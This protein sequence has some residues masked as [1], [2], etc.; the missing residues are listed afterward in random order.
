MRWLGIAVLV[1]AACTPAVSAAP[2]P[3]ASPSPIPTSSPTPSPVPTR[4]FDVTVHF[5]SHGADDLVAKWTTELPPAWFEATRGLS[6]VTVSPTAGWTVNVFGGRGRSENTPV[7]IMIYAMSP[8]GFMNVNGTEY[9]DIHVVMHEMAHQ[10][11]CCRGPDTEGGHFIG[12]P[13]GLMSAPVQCVC[14][15]ND[16]EIAALFPQPR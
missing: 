6:R 4:N 2:L 9:S 14:P 1:L 8:V 13:Q 10:M 3:T 15:F 7:G 12:P 11:G 5:V 16:R